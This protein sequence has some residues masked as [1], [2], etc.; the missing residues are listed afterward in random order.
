MRHGV[1]AYAEYLLQTVYKHSGQ[2]QIGKYGKPEIVQ[3]GEP[4]YF[5]GADSGGWIICAFADRPLGVDLQQVKPD[6]R[7]LGVA[8]RMF[9]DADAD[10]LERVPIRRRGAVF[11][12]N[13]A[14]REAV[15]KWTG[16]G[17]NLPMSAFSIDGDTPVG[18]D[19]PED[20]ALFAI[21]GFD[22]RRYAAWVCGQYK[23]KP[24]IDVIRD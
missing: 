4:L 5:N 13:W 6:R 23:N 3:E 8:R 9:G 24:R 22:S 18:P 10:A 17:F 1:R 12:E 15:M 7:I 21:P 11:A 14:K 2:I 19:F 20:L 16:R